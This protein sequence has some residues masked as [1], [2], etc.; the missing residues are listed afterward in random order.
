MSKITIL[1]GNFSCWTNCTFQSFTS[2]H[3][4]AL[5]LFRKQQEKCFY[6]IFNL[7][8][9]QILL[10]W[11]LWFRRGALCFMRTVY[12]SVHFIN[13][14]T[15]K[16]SQQYITIAVIHCMPFML[17]FHQSDCVSA[18][19]RMLFYYQHISIFVPHMLKSTA[20]CVGAKTL[21]STK[22]YTYSNP[23]IG[24]LYQF[25][26]VTVSLC[27]ELYVSRLHTRSW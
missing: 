15:W 10:Q 9:L 13:R 25:I 4:W 8:R 23:C 6:L 11:F 27:W 18:I 2:W 26:L 24:W 21:Y 22:L 17:V 7:D 16:S 20:F 12:K 14:F 3:S 1:S 19:K 5:P